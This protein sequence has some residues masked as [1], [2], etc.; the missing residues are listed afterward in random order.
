MQQ[1]GIVYTEVFAS[2]S[3][4]T[5]LRTLLALAAAEDMELHQ[6]HIKSIRHINVTYCVCCNT[7]LHS[8]EPCSVSCCMQNHSFFEK[9][10]YIG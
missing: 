9:L 1:E 8:G 5:P 10:L 6:L 7:H 2:V 3:K 4:H